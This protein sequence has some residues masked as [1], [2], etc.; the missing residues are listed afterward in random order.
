MAACGM[1][2]FLIACLKGHVGMVSLFLKNAWDLE[3][4]VNAKDKKKG[5]SGLALAVLEGNLEIVKLLTGLDQF[6]DIDLNTTDTNGKT[7]LMHA[8]QKRFIE[9]VSYFLKLAES[10]KS[11]DFNLNAKDEDGNTAFH[12]ACLNKREDI[13]DL[14][15]ESALKLKIEL[16]IKNDDSKTGHDLWP[17]KFADENED[18][19]EGEEDVNEAS[20]TKSLKVDQFEQNPNTASRAFTVPTPRTPEMPHLPS[21]VSPI[22]TPILPEESPYPYSNYTIGESS[23]S[24]SP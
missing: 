23:P 12:H 13:V 22:N 1:N 5:R 9:I 10:K 18:E 19:D 20:P 14:I 17:D 7:P 2:G 11:K 6:I 16:G 3:L 15:I 24:A 8:C 21:M 4:D